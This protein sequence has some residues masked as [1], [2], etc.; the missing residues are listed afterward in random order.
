MTAKKDLKRRVR[1]RQA[2]T[3]ESYTAAR[4]HVL[5]G[6]QDARE[7]AF[8]VLELIDVS[9]DAHRLGLTGSVLVSQTI[10]SRVAP[11]RILEQLRDA[12]LATKHDPDLWLLRAALLRGETV[13]SEWRGNMRQWWESCQRFYARARAGIGGTSASGDMLA[14]V[15]DDTMI[16]V[17]IGYEPR[18]PG[19]RQH[20]F[21]TSVDATQVDDGVLILPG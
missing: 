14:L 8:P 12:L 2:K 11:P 7:P 3:G 16:V 10:A 18:L 9:D 17:Q 15:V 13:K 21:L 20:V 1:E 5:A 4:A 6:A 19:R